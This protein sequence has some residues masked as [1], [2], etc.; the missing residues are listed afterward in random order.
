LDARDLAG[1][2]QSEPFD[3]DATRHKRRPAGST[4]HEAVKVPFCFS[5]A[6]WLHG[7]PSPLDARDLVGSD[8]SEPFGCDA[9]RHKRCPPVQRTMKP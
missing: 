1:C 4:H 9:T 3:C 2:N 6:P 5:D 7:L 8:H